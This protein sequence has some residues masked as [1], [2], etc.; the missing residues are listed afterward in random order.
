[1]TPSTLPD[2]KPRDDVPV[3][4]GVPGGAVVRPPQGPTIRTAADSMALAI[5]ALDADTTPGALLGEADVEPCAF[6][7]HHGSRNPD[8][9]AFGPDDVCGEDSMPGGDYCERHA[10][11][12]S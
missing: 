8:S 3:L 9:P 4:V 6:V 1:M 10:G 11:G 12:A 2:L 5:V 7:V